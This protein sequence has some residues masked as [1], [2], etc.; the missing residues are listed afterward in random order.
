MWY[1]DLFR[2]HLLDM[3]IE[4]WDEEFLSAFSPETYVENL[5]KARISG[6]A[7]A[8]NPASSRQKAARCPPQ[9][10]RDSL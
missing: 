1:S 8:A 10:H 9:Q 2:R 4:D 3:H 6:R 7:A 5:K